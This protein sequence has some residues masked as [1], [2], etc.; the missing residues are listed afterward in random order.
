MQGR[1]HKGFTLLEVLIV[2]LIL[3]ILL[4]VAVPQFL[5]SRSLSRQRTCLSNLRQLNSAKDQFA[6]AVNLSNGDPVTAQDL[7]P[8]YI[9][10]FPKC[11]GGGT[12]SLNTI[13]DTA[14]CSIESGSHPHKS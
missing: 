2:A 3:G 6:V 9:K 14:R 5:N 11:P 13:G 12:Y 10:Q 7:A 1:I 4:S 8:D